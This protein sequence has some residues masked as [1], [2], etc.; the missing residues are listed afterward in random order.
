MLDYNENLVSFLPVADMNV[1][2][3]TTCQN[4][5]LNYQLVKRDKGSVMISFEQ[6]AKK[7]VEKC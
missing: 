6:T 4:V 7:G 1:F 5:T 2:I 3:D